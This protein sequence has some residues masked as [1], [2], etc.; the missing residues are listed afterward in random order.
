MREAGLLAAELLMKLG[1][2]AKPGV[3][4]LELDEAAVAFARKHDV[5]NA[6]LDYKGFPRSICTSINE[7]V[8]HG[9]PQKRD[10]LEDGDLISID[11]TLVKNGFH[12]D[13]CATYFVGEPSDE[14]RRL[15][16]VTA[17]SLVKGLR[18]VKPG[19][20]IGDI[21]YAIQRHAEDAG[22]SVVREFQGHGIGR[23]FHT[24]P[25]VPHFGKRGSG[26]RL[27][28]GMSFTIEPMIN[29]GDWPTKVLDDGWTAVTKDGSLSAQFE[30]TIVVTDDGFE[31]MTAPK[32]SDPLRVSPGLVVEIEE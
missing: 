11:V 5:V 14:A 19:N 23:K 18:K 22:F 31:A 10:V 20:R 30:H 1:E 12:G 13:N 8:C 7:V 15:V 27:R 32:G 2:M 26:M 21:G 17:E 9:I 24:A 28:P 16:Q 25:D 6:P 4:T 3:S 29:V